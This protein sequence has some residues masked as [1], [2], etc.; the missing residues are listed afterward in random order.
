M[1]ID[2]YNA[3]TEDDLLGTML[4]EDKDLTAT[5]GENAY[6]IFRAMRRLLTGENKDGDKLYWLKLTDAPIYA[7]YSPDNEEIAK[8]EE[9]GDKHYKFTFSGRR[10]LGEYTY[11]IFRDTN[12]VWFN[13]AYYGT[14][15]FLNDTATHNGTEIEAIQFASDM[16]Y[17]SSWI[18]DSCKGLDA[19]F[20]GGEHRRRVKAT[21]FKISVREYGRIE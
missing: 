16:Y 19:P 20:F 17:Y 10:I 8:V 7:L 14:E 15:V 3:F 18:E 13:G 6:D 5:A 1:L 21:G 4:E 9:L 11:E 2:K 12:E